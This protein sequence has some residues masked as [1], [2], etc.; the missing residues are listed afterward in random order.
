MLQRASHLRIK[1]RHME[2]L[3]RSLAGLREDVE[4]ILEALEI[5]HK[6]MKKEDKEEGSTSVDGAGT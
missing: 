1:I 6:A 5:I 3:A 4:A 2:T